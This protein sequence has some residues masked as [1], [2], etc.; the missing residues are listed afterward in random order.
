MKNIFE[1]VINRG[2]YNLNSL[3]NRI[4]EYHVDGRLNDEERDHLLQLA[5][6]GAKVPVNPEDEISQLWAAIRKLTAR[7]EELEGNDKPTG[8]DDVDGTVNEF[9]QP[10][11]A[12]DAYFA[13]DMVVW[14][15]KVYQCTAPDGVACVWDPDA[16]PGYWTEAIAGV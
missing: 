16:M 13:G 15:G 7:V 1:Q 6:K 12:H 14:G 4:H 8:G 3:I 11:G 10:A 2:S 9:K 5:R